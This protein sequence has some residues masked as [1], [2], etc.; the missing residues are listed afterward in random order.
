M[1]VGM[2]ME[3]IFQLLPGERIIG[4]AYHEGISII[5]SDFTVYALKEKGR[6][7]F[8][9]DIEVIRHISDSARMRPMHIYNSLDEAK[10]LVTKAQ[11]AMGLPIDDAGV[12]KLL[13]SLRALGLTDWIEPKPAEVDKDAEA[14]RVKL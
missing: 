11:A 14:R 4:I 12:R 9:Y 3:Q 2:G 1:D 5:A 7:L 8:D 6:Q 13:V 10:D